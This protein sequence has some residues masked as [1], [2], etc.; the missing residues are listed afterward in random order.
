MLNLTLALAALAG[1]LGL[2]GLAAAMLL[3]RT[4]YASAIVVAAAR[5]SGMADWPALLAQILLPLI[6]CAGVVWILGQ[7]AP[8]DGAIGG[9]ATFVVY[10]LAL[11]PLVPF[12][13]V[14]LRG[15]RQSAPSEAGRG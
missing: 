1:G 8:V 2:E 4:V 5:G 7:I 11:L 14:V 10:V 6:W 9:L 15:L 3:G 12:G 13:R